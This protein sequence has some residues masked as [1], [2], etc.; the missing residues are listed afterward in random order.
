MAKQTIEKKRDH[1]RRERALACQACGSRAETSGVRERAC[2]GSTCRTGRAASRD[3]RGAQR[4]RGQTGQWVAATIKLGLTLDSD[5]GERTQLN[6]N[7][8]KL[9]GELAERGVKIDLLAAIATRLPE[10]AV[11]ISGE[12]LSSR[13]R[14]HHPSAAAYGTLRPEGNRAAL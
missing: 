11:T 6:D 10:A 2:D 13:E 14:R 9:V 7:A 8:R 3:D 5:E 1:A 4:P 12:A